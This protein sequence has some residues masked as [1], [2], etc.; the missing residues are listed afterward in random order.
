MSDSEVLPGGRQVIM[1]KALRHCGRELTLFGTEYNSM[2]KGIVENNR[3]LGE[4]QF[5]DCL[6]LCD[7]V[8]TRKWPS[9]QKFNREHQ[10][11]DTAKKNPPSITVKLS[12][13]RR[14]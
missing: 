10:G 9:N 12:E 11:K 14:A 5:Q 1:K 4:E 6:K 8:S 13:S 7:T 3:D 2:P